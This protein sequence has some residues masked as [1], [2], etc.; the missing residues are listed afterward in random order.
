[1]SL[2]HAWIPFPDA[3]WCHVHL[4]KQ[5]PASKKQHGNVLPSYWSEKRW[6]QNVCGEKNPE[7]KQKLFEADERMPIFAVKGGLYQYGLKGHLGERGECSSYSKL[8]IKSQTL[9]F[10]FTWGNKK[11]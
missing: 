2:N 1:M 11:N 4:F 5:L 7:K 10:K 6:V 9:V 3:C 8:N